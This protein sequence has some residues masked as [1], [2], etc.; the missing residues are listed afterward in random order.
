MVDEVSHSYRFGPFRLDPKQRLLFRDGEIIPLTVKAFETLLVLIRKRGRV[1]DKNE[2]LTI[3]WPDTFV[4]EATLA[5]N[6]FTLRKVLRDNS[7]DDDEYIRTIPKRGYCF[8]GRVT[9][10]DDESPNVDADQL[11]EPP[12]IRRG[13]TSS[14]HKPIHHLAV[15]PMLNESAEPDAEYFSG[16]ISESLVNGLS[17]FPDLHVK[18]C[19]TVVRYKGREVDPQEAGRELGVESVLIG[20]VLL[21]GDSIIVRVELVDVANGWQV[22]GQQYTE[23]RSDILKVHEGIA[24]NILEKLSLKLASADLKRLFRP[25]TKS[26]EAYQLYLKGRHFLT[27]RT[28]EGYKTAIK[29]FEQAIEFD[30]D[31]SLAYAGLA[32]SY[33]RFDFYGMVPPS[34]I[35]PK[36]KEAAFKARE[37][38]PNLAESH[39]SLGSIKLVYD[40]DIPGAE[41]EFKLAIKLNPKLAHAHDGYAHC[42]M[43][44]GRKEESLAECRLALELEP[45]DPEINMHLGG[46]YL[47]ARQ[48]DQAVEQLLKTLELSPDFY[49]ARLLLAIAYGQMGSFSEAIRVFGRARKMS[50]TPVLSGFLGYALAMAGRKEEALA[51]LDQLLQ[52]S[53]RTYVPPYCIALIYTGLGQ[54]DEAIEWLERASVEQSRWRGWLKLTPELDSLRLDT[55]FAELLQRIP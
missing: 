42:L 25:K 26:A 27:K 40:R 52:Q 30:P 16:G 9:E 31:Y 55:K 50:E 15:L 48:Y 2:L 5:Q 21:F 3:V 11:I 8:V 1:V 18:A 23:K 33:V 35:I 53:K 47:F 37:I 7:D 38:D 32:D 49:R 36:A 24:K 10:V 54:R 22:W 17:L 41:R 19:S 29:A 34:E 14:R 45:F 39:N 43:D 28:E 12:L 44:M 6:V 4:G 51:L 20:K 13:T 46:H